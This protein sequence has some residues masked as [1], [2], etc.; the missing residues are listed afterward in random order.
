MP[1]S[2]CLCYLGEKRSEGQRTEMQTSR[3]YLTSCSMLT[4][5]G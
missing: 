3:C 2:K 5:D 4:E 1:R